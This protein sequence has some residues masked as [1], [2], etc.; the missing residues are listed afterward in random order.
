LK[1]ISEFGQTVPLALCFTLRLFGH[2]AFG[3]GAAKNGSEIE[4]LRTNARLSVRDAQIMHM[5]P[6]VAQLS[7]KSE[8]RIQIRRPVKWHEDYRRHG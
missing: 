7:G 2:C 4:A 5:M 8:S 3:K 1:A 6:T